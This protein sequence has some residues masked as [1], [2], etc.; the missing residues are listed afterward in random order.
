MLYQP[1]LVIPYYCLT[2][3]R[4]GKCGNGRKLWVWHSSSGGRRRGRRV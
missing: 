2:A 3:D 1:Q 4:D